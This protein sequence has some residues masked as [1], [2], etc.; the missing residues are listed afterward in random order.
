MTFIFSAHIISCLW[1]FIGRYGPNNSFS[2]I[3][4]ISINN[5]D[6]LDCYIHSFYWTIA[7]MATT[8]YGDLVAYNLY[9]RIF[10]IIIQLLGAIIY[11]YLVGNITA[12]SS[13]SSIRSI[14][15][16]NKIDELK[17]Y[18]KDRKVPS[19]IRR[20]ITKY[21]QYLY[22]HR[23]VFDENVILSELSNNI[24]NQIIIEVHL[25]FVAN[26]KLFVGED[27][28]VVCAFVTRL[29]PMYHNKG[30][31]IGNE[32]W[33][34][35]EM[36][37]L[38]KGEVE[39]F[40]DYEKSP[41]T[42]GIYNTGCYFGDASLIL[43]MRSPCSFSSITY[44][45]LYF[46]NKD[47]VD[48]ITFYF[49]AIKDKLTNTAK[50]R[51]ANLNKI[52]EELRSTIS[53]KATIA[54]DTPLYDYD[55]PRKSTP[56]SFHISSP[57]QSFRSS[58]IKSPQTLPSL[59]TKP[60]PSR[61]KLSIPLTQT[62]SKI[63]PEIDTPL[64]GKDKNDTSPRLPESV[65]PTKKRLSKTLS[66][67]D[68]KLKTDQSKLSKTIAL[69]SSNP[70][71]PKN[72]FKKKKYRRS[73][74]QDLADSIRENL[75][76]ATHV[77]ARRTNALL[78]T[79]LLC[80]GEMKKVEGEF[81][82]KINEIINQK[83]KSKDEKE[84]RTDMGNNLYQNVEQDIEL[85]NEMNKLPKYI[86]H[87]EN[88]YYLLFQILLFIVILFNSIEVPYRV[89]FNAEP[90]EAW[91]FFSVLFD[92]IFIADIV[93]HFFTAYYRHLDYLESDYK[94]IRKHYIRTTFI[95]DLLSSIPIDLIFYLLDFDGHMHLKSYRLSK[96]LRF[97]KL[98]RLYKL[99]RLFAKF[100]INFN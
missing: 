22:K 55:T 62:S 66:S 44:C 90:N 48:E 38:V 50:E 70:V 24:R 43:E 28:N 97:L 25:D 49:K 100:T 80:N 69:P 67:E 52:K 26:C 33:I 59:N 35:R 19:M 21:F 79:Y 11:G 76:S 10:A 84:K 46:I 39:V 9:E 13:D 57:S 7:T 42:V 94:E 98:L 87:P 14:V 53:R 36:Y 54:I 93:I 3:E 75:T 5:N 85:Y 61:I 96:L 20:K 71:S 81:K 68:L 91:L 31:L 8:G 32:G 30:D 23:S 1:F 12:I 65:T 78:L 64:T 41:F 73:I 88:K 45:D 56:T 6:L 4:S 51:V 16:E 86:L 17:Q 89:G 58:F 83:S 27:R 60:L 2:W 37:F 77:V 34:F 29:R 95:Y 82:D 63:A 92:I 74:G 40:I 72:L 15:F 18:L 99:L 47:D